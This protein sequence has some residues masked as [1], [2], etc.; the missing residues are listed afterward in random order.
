LLSAAGTDH[1]GALGVAAG[2]S[3]ATTAAGLFLLFG[4]A[5]W[6]AALGR[7]ITMFPEK[8]LIVRGKRECL[9]AIAA[10][11]LLIFSHKSLSSI[12]SCVCVADTAEV[13]A[14]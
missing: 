11:E 1:A 6:F 7:R 10:H 12:L 5:A 3:A 14:V 13:P 9:P 8:V 2:V 4:G